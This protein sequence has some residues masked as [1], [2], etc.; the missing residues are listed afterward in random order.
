[1][2]RDAIDARRLPPSGPPGICLPTTARAGRRAG[3]QPFALPSSESRPGDRASQRQKG[4][5]GAASLG[6]WPANRNDEWVRARIPVL[7]EER[8]SGVNHTDLAKLLEDHEDIV[9]PVRTLGRIL[10][11]EGHPSPSPHHSPRH[12]G[13]R[14]RRERAG[15]LLQAEG[16]EHRRFGPEWPN[17]ALV[18]SID[19]AT[20]EV[21]GAT[22]REREDA[23]G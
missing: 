23:A 17:V 7:V 18:R 1:V 5:S 14:A 21:T 10:G 15:Q 13:R 4:W 9:I 12:R 8:Y 3:T 11:D 16:S 20:I 22:F 19:D 6:R 2:N